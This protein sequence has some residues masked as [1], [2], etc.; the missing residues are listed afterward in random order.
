MD[1]TLL[2]E[3]AWFHSLWWTT[4]NFSKLRDTSKTSRM[5]HT[6][7]SC[8][9]GVDISQPTG[10]L[11]NISAALLPPWTSNKSQYCPYPSCSCRASSP[12]QE[13]CMGTAAAPLAKRLRLHPSF[14]TYQPWQVQSIYFFIII[15][16]I[17]LGTPP[18]GSSM[19]PQQ[20]WEH[21]SKGQLLILGTDTRLPKL[22]PT[23]SEP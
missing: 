20:N 10:H 7:H 14:Q 13:S 2:R 5:P 22:S 23:Q 3:I 4:I 17:F 19:S 12:V 9:T 16:L 1:L 15:I 6:S 18:D 11:H 8:P 21:F